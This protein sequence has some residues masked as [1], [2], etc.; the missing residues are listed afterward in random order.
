MSRM[1]ILN[2]KKNQG[3]TLLETV[4][5]VLILGIVIT[6]TVGAFTIGRFMIASANDHAK[7]L[8]LLRAE[9]EKIRGESYASLL[10]NVDS[11]IEEDID[12]GL[13]NDTITTTITR[14]YV[15]RDDILTVTLT[16][17]WEL[18]GR[19]S[20]ALSV[21]EQIVTLVCMGGIS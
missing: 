12:S 2:N 1:F 17:D 7:A 9:M 11:P 19:F 6:S 4:I 10:G 18:P 16:L 5:S 21:S 3:F 15:G 8:N 14:Y 20:S 13:L